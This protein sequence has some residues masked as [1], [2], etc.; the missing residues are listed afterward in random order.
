MT[1]STPP[2]RAVAHADTSSSRSG[3]ATRAALWALAVAA[4]IFCASSRSHVVTTGVTRIDDKFV[5]F[6]VYGLLATL[7]CRVRGGWRGAIW[8]LLLTSAYGASDEWHQS[9]VPGRSSDVADWIADTAG[10]ALGV[11]LYAGWPAYRRR[12][13]RSLWSRQL[14]I[15][16]SSG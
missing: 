4:L 2:A 10:A 15:E 12:L 14:R 1:E 8:A 5:H 7:V 16:K 13:E 11:L 9:F 3:S 6:S